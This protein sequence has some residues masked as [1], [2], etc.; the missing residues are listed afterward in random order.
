MSGWLRFALNKP[1]QYLGWLSHSHDILITWLMSWIHQ[2]WSKVHDSPVI[3]HKYLPLYHGY[4]MDIQ[5]VTSKFPWTNRFPMDFPISNQHFPWIF[6]GFPRK[7][8]PSPSGPGPFRRPSYPIPWA[9]RAPDASPP[10]RWDPS[11]TGLAQ[12]LDPSRDRADLTT[13]RNPGQ[14]FGKGRFICR[15]VERKKYQKWWI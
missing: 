3:N 14:I 11:G 13:R 4:F 12:H 7:K 5:I 1:N 6:H 9:T 10:K 2:R 8:T 15:D